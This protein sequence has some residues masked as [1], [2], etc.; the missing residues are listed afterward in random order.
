MMGFDALIFCTAVNDIKAIACNPMVELIVKTARCRNI[1]FFLI[2]FSS[3]IL[4][5]VFPLI[6][7]WFNAINLVILFNIKR[8]CFF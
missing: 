1:G 7:L 4:K 3:I 2:S 6:L 8:L 5:T